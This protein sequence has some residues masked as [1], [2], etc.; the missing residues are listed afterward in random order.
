MKV[1]SLIVLRRIA[2]KIDSY[3]CAYQSGFVTAKAVWCHKWYTTRVHKYNETYTV[4]GIDLSCAFDLIDR[5]K[6]LHILA[7]II[8]D[9]ELH[10]VKLLITDTTIDVRHMSTQ[11]ASFLT[12]VG[13]PQGDSLSRYS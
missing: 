8:N 12:N 7:T 10:L 5:N 3:M 2:S 6:M 13:T 9:D 1:I 11:S 4:L